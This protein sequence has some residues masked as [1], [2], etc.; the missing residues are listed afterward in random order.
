[1]KCSAAGAYIKGISS[2]LWENG[3]FVRT[4]KP[5]PP[6]TTVDLT[7]YL[8]DNDLTRVIG[9]VRTTAQTGLIH[10]KNGMG[11]EII[12]YDQNFVTFMNSLLRV[13]EHT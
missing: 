12:Q 2:C 1:M 3:L 13:E 4:S 6:D 5:F 11:I 9:V 10:R 7:I 8:N